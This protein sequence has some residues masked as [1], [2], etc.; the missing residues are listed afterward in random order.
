MNRSKQ[1]LS[2]ELPDIKVNTLQTN[3]HVQQLTGTDEVIVAQEN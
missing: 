1:G 2:E 3:F